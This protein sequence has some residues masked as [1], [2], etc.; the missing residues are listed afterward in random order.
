MRLVRFS[1]VSLSL[2][3]VPG[4]CEAKTHPEYDV[5]TW[6]QKSAVVSLH[7]SFPLTLPLSLL[8]AFSGE[9]ITAER[10]HEYANRTRKD[11][12]DC[13]GIF[14][15]FH[16]PSASRPHPRFLARFFHTLASFP[17][18]LLKLYILCGTTAWVKPR[19]F[20]PRPCREERKLICAI[21]DDISLNVRLPTLSLSLSLPLSLSTIRM[22]ELC[23]M[24]YLDAFTTKGT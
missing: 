20:V 8:L 11:T 23:L 2:D 10:R 13:R 19:F 22:Y 17:R 18:Y 5:C 4:S 21:C 7:G 6:M 24:K 16:D 1:P 9:L 12:R 3:R 14:H 15:D